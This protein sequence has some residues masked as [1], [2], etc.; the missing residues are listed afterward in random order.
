[1]GSFCWTLK[2]SGCIVVDEVLELSGVM[3][4]FNIK[5]HTSMSNT[6]LMTHNNDKYL[7]TASRILVAIVIYS[8]N[9]EFVHNSV[10]E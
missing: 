6:R 3:T 4:Y 9:I 7:P 10:E 1:M 2:Q 5:K 8:A